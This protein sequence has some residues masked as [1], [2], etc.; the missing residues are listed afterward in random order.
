MLK[1]WYF[2]LKR[3]ACIIKFAQTRETMIQAA[4]VVTKCKDQC[5]WKA[6]ICGKVREPC[7]IKVCNPCVTC[8]WLLWLLFSKNADDQWFSYV[9]KYQ[10][11]IMDK[12]HHC[13]GTTKLKSQFKTIITTNVIFF[14]SSE[15]ALWLG[16][17]SGIPVRAQSPSGK[18]SR[19]PLYE[20]MRVW[21][22][23]WPGMAMCMA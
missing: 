5:V 11:K 2:V 10:N 21:K 8:N 15:E 22:K 6:A 1:L 3:A 20:G 13:V 14:V 16:F 19:W 17:L 7:M 12:F 4:N 9:R 23:G 18:T